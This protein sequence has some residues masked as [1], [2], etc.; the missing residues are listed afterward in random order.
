MSEK[1]LASG[2]TI[3]TG[4]IG[5]AVIALLVSRQANTSAVI[6]A[7]ASGFSGALCTALSPITG[8]CVGG[9]GGLIPSVNSTITFGNTPG[10]TQ[11]NIG[12]NQIPF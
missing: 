11:P 10:L 12:S 9:S 4:I 7:S 6:G 8:Q 3:L 5:V 1:F 2:V